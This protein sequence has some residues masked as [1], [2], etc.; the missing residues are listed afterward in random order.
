MHVHGHTSAGSARL[1][2]TKGERTASPRDAN[3]TKTRPTPGGSM[4]GPTREGC[5]MLT[6]ASAPYLVSSSHVTSSTMSA[7]SSSSS[8]SARVT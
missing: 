7:Y 2:F 6:L 1:R 4:P 3:C 8:S 5:G